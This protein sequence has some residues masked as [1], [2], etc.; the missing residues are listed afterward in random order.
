MRA[1]LRHTTVVAD[2]H[3]IANVLGVDGVLWMLEVCAGLPLE[4]YVM[5]P[6]CVPASEFEA[7]RGPLTVV[8]MERILE[9]DHA[10]GIG[11]M[12][13]FPGV[14]AGDSEQLRKLALPG[15]THVDGH[16]PGVR[17]PRLDAYLAAGIRSDHE[18][19]TYEEALE[20]RRKGSW[21]FLREASNAH[22]LL[23]LLPLV[24]EHGTDLCAFCT[25]D[26]DPDH[27]LREGGINHM[28]VWRSS[29]GSQPRMR[30]FW[31]R[32]AQPA[33]MDS[34]STVR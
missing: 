24:L 13:N 22:N 19:A 12:M 2:P 26:R 30:L 25:D 28:V 11:E 34:A 3:E 6:S 10:L 27:L 18:S 9:R 16:A 21:I 5:V 1:A 20:K 8:D 17:G 14:I 15:A 33:R 7:P 29:A 23:D 4:V 31:P 32:S